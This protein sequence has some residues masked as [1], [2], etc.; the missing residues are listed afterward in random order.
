MSEPRTRCDVEYRAGLQLPDLEISFP[1]SCGGKGGQYLVGRNSVELC[2][3][4]RTLVLHEFAHAWDDNSNVDRE[5]FLERRRK[6]RSLLT[7]ATALGAAA[8]VVRS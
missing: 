6:R 3:P 8:H 2:H 4:N 7:K 5:A 1:A